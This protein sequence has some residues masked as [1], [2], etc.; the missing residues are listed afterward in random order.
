MTSSAPGI[1][2]ARSPHRATTKDDRLRGAAARARTP[3]ITRPD[4]RVSDWLWLMLV[5]GLVIVLV[6]SLAGVIWTVVDGNDSTSPDVIVTVFSSTLAGL[7]A[8]FVNTP[9]K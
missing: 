8:L 2:E 1:G 9:A 3:R 7:I 6:V 4:R 5:S